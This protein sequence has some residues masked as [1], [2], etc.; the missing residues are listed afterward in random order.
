MDRI[1]HLSNIFESMLG[2]E[3]LVRT[4]IANPEN[5]VYFIPSLENTNI[6]KALYAIYIDK[7]FIKARECFYQAARVD[8]YMSVKFDWRIIDS[9]TFPISYALLSDNEALIQR[10]TVLK[11]SIND[12]T[13]IGY[14]LANAV[15]NILLSSLDALDINIRNLERFVKFPQFRWCLSPL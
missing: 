7:D 2:D 4:K 3:A 11:N 14:Q 6:V 10:Y 1:K 13:T 15:Q 5:R 12:T 9:G 8:E